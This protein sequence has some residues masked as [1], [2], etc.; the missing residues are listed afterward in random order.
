MITYSSSFSG[1][2]YPIK[3][4]LKFKKYGA[5]NI[6]EIRKDITDESLEILNINDKYFTIVPLGD[7]VLADRN[8]KMGKG[9]GKIIIEYLEKENINSENNMLELIYSFEKQVLELMSISAASYENCI[10][11]IKETK[12]TEQT[13]EEYL[14]EKGFFI[15]SKIVNFKIT[16]IVKEKVF[17]ED[18]E[19][20][21][22]NIKDIK[23]EIEKDFFHLK[24]FKILNI[25]Y[26]IGEK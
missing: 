18:E 19:E 4:A 14:K 15:K 25:T 1:Y 23:E 6:N 17:Y 24:E 26:K 20:L 12:D 3:T 10:K 5:S 7:I 2:S 13:P 9:N 22:E 11:A 21:I 16:S 8:F